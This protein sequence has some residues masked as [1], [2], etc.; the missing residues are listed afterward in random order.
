MVE[1]IVISGGDCV[2]VGEATRHLVIVIQVREYSFNQYSCTFLHAQAP[3]WG[4]RCATRRSWGIGAAS[5]CGPVG[6]GVEWSSE[7]EPGDLEL[8]T[9]FREVTVTWEDAAC[10]HSGPPASWGPQALG[11]EGLAWLPWPSTNCVRP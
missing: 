7:L 3:S 6:A 10:I 8:R 9:T 2:S 1:P 11:P 5:G 4:W